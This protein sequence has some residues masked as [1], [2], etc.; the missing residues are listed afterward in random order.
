[1]LL[2]GMQRGLTNLVEPVAGSRRNLLR[3]S[4]ARVAFAANTVLAS[5]PT[6]MT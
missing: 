3:D 1:M 2:S 4:R 5:S 6:R